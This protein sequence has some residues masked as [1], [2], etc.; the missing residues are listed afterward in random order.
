MKYTASVSPQYFS[1][2]CVPSSIQFRKRD[3]CLQTSESF[4]E[5]SLIAVI[6]KSFIINDKVGMKECVEVPLSIKIKALHEIDQ[7]K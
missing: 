7:M 3:I 2:N 4:Y 5:E 1:N 6:S